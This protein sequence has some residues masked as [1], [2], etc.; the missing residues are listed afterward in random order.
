MDGSRETGGEYYKSLFLL[1][2]Q[3]PDDDDQHYDDGGQDRSLELGCPPLVS[4]QI[5]GL[6]TSSAEVTDES[7]LGFGEFPLEGVLQDCFFFPCPVA[8][9]GFKA[10]Y[11]RRK[12][13]YP[14]VHFTDFPAVVIALE[15]EHT[16]IAAAIAPEGGL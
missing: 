8:E 16:L 10:P 6:E 7:S 14:L 11:F 5:Y 2:E 15:R 3:D 13:G 1:P 12:C 9:K 4:P